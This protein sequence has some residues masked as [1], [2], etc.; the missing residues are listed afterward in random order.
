MRNR[1]EKLSGATIFF[2]AILPAVVVGYWAGAAG[3]TQWGLLTGAIIFGSMAIATSVDHALEHIAYQSFE[4]NE[5][6]RQ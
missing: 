6:H 1:Q 3:G 4:L 2:A 5:K